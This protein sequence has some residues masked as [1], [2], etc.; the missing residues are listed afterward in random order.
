MPSPV[1]PLAFEAA[2]G[3]VPAAAA[4]LEG[5]GFAAGG[6]GFGLHACVEGGYSPELS[7]ARARQELSFAGVLLGDATAQAFCKFAI[8][9]TARRRDGSTPRRTARRRDDATVLLFE[10]MFSID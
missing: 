1:A 5:V 2:V 10:H 3:L 7:A 6:A 8:P 4:D 9:A